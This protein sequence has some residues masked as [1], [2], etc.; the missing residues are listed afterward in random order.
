M[1]FKNFPSILFD[2]LFQSSL[3]TK[4]IIAKKKMGW[5]ECVVIKI[6]QLENVE[7]V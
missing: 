4:S 5:P 1:H 2:L 7:S 6:V 3:I